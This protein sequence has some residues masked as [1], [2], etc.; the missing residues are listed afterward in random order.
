MG[1]GECLG[2]HRGWGE[3][4][5][6]E[7]GDTWAET[8]RSGAVNRVGVS[9]PSGRWGDGGQGMRVL[10]TCLLPPVFYCG[11]MRPSIL[12]NTSVIHAGVAV[13]GWPL[14]ALVVDPA[15]CLLSSPARSAA[16]RRGP[17]HVPK[18]I[19]HAQASLLRYGADRYKTFMGG[20]GHA[21][22]HQI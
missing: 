5:G 21:A 9:R 15:A 20:R 17:P 4:T 1:S 16:G 12:L 14:T 22:A 7:N 8:V 18:N 13:V 19:G 11:G 6:A 2:K 3:G 10:S